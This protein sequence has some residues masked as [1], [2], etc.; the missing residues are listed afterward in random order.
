[1]TYQTGPRIV[2]NGLVFCVDAADTNSYPGTGTTW[3][4]LLTSG[5]TGTLTNG[6]TFNSSNRGSIVFDGTNDYID[7]GNTNIGVD[8]TDKSFCA[9]VYFGSSLNNPTGIIDK[10]FDN[11]GTNYG[12]WGFWVQSNRKLWWWNHGNQDLLDDG[13]VTIGTNIWTHIAVTYNY[14]TKTAIF[15]INGVL[16]SSKTNASIVEKSSSTSNLVIGCIRGA[17]GGFANGRI[18]N[19]SAYNKV[20][21]A[22][23]ILQNYNA[24]KGRYNL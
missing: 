4:D 1:M 21:S 9:W 5:R 18:S 14:S 6:P 10:D 2:T 23:E 11:G 16:N 17:A 15:Y 24:T 8:L 20:L 12:G 13:S 7:F 3:S 22:T 19:V